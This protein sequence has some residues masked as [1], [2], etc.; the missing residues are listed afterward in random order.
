MKK[1]LLSIVFILSYL[2]SNAQY[3]GCAFTL[4]PDSS[5]IVQDSW[6]TIDTLYRVKGKH[7]G[8]SYFRIY[9]DKFIVDK[10]KVQKNFTNT[11]NFIISDSITGE[12]YSTR[13]IPFSRVSGFSST[14]VTTALGFTPLSS[15]YTGFDSRYLQL[16]NFTWSNVL[17][18]P[19]TLSGFGI[20]DGL[21]STGNGSALT[22]LTKSQV[23]LGNCDNTSDL[24]KPISTATQTALNGKLSAEV[25]GSVT[26]EIQ[27]LSITGNQV[28]ISSGNTIT[29]P[30]PAIPDYYNTVNVSGG[31][32]TAVFYLTSDKTATGTAL[33]STVDIA[34]PFINDATQNYTYGVSTYN[35]TTKSITVTAKTNLTA[36][37]SLLTV[38]LGPTTVNNGTPIGIIVK[39]H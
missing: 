8:F 16:T 22:G 10:W 11:L 12:T 14:S 27:S 23:G 20:T 28:T 18:K 4:F 13:F 24:N 25:D 15:S 32:G 19:T 36:V 9:T 5:C 6:T 3:N 34:I 39:G 26:N 17:S 30:I 35:P 2:I 31:S 21:T 33:Y 7:G 38:V 1:T 29:L 37:I